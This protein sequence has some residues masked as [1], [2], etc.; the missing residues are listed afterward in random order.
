MPIRCVVLDLDG[1]L[2][3]SHQ[4]ISIRNLQ[5][6]DSCRAQGIP[7]V[8]ATGRPPRA[9]RQWLALPSFQGLVIYLDGA[10]T[11]DE[12]CGRVYDHRTIP[13]AI[14]KDIVTA[15]LLM[16]PQAIIS[17]EVQDAWYGLDLDSGRGEIGVARDSAKA[18]SLML[19]LTQ[20]STLAPTKILVSGFPNWER[21]MKPFSSSVK[22]AVTAS[23]NLIQILEKS[24]AKEQALPIVL[25]SLR[26]ARGEVMAMG[27][28][29]NDLGLMQYC[30]Y[31]VAMGNAVEALKQRARY[32]TGSND[33]DGVAWALA[34]AGIAF[35]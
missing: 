14:A 25:E 35:P 26:V 23:G 27:D 19:G 15:V 24:V 6:L 16:E 10:L 3:N 22:M 1:T 34:H 31:P 33:E 21:L 2:L 28:G 32:I 13:A 8:I 17:F 18:R 20:L 9:V 11:I 12:S 7:V 30:G 29:L 4:E 5:A